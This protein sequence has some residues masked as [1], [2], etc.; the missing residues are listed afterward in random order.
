VASL[1]VAGGGAALVAGPLLG[2]LLILATS[3]P[4]WL[5]NVVAGIVYA[6]TMPVVALITAY[7]YFDVRVRRELADERAPLQLPAEI[8]LSR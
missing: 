5:V 1:I 4:L 8:E 7:V 2:A 6:V 3:A